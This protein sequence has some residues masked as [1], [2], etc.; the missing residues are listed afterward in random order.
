[1]GSKIKKILSQLNT[2]HCALRAKRGFA[3]IELVVVMGIFVVVSSLVLANNT[4]FGGSVLLQNLAYDIAL[5]IRQAQVYGIAV[6]GASS[7]NFSAGYGMYF[8]SAPDKNKTYVLFADLNGNGIYDP[9]PD[10]S[11]D[12]RVAS[13]DIGRN[14]KISRLC[15]PAS[16][17]CNEINT[18]DRLDIVFKRPEPDASIFAD[19][20]T[21]GTEDSAR[22]VIASPRGDTKSIVVERNGQISVQN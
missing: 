2:T 1:M 3:L 15:A 21:S 4:R 17:E 10:D 16:T 11:I 7:S 22:I 18:V 13:T 14:Y 8:E 5:T 19:E 6:R 12:A 20:I 9:T